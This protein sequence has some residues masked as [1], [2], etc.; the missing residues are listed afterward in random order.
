MVA[1]GALFFALLVQLLQ[2]DA[3]SR[4]QNPWQAAKP[5]VP[6]A[7]Y[8]R[9]RSTIVLRFFS[10]LANGHPTLSVIDQR[11]SECA[12]SSPFPL[13]RGAVQPVIPAPPHPAP[14]TAP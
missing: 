10:R 13:G 6:K 8:S 5:Q 1:L 7:P 12:H 4:F 14:P 9:V 3:Y 11:L 2:L